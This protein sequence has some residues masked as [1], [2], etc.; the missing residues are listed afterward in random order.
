MNTKRQ[1]HVVTTVDALGFLLPGAIATFIV[2]RVIEYT[3]PPLPFAIPT[4]AMGWGVFVVSALVLGFMI[5]PLA[6]VL[7]R[8]YEKVYRRFRDVKNDTLV[9]FAERE[10]KLFIG[11][12]GSVFDF[13]RK[14]IE[15]A[16]VPKVVKIRRMEGISKLARGVSFFALLAAI[17]AG[18][19]EYW[20]AC[21][22]FLLL[23]VI[24]FFVF[25][26]TRWAAT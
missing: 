9:A 6:Q 21:T 1:D 5:Q 7:D 10:A 24:A 2:L 12:N 11:P 4:G 15:T 22:S 8:V 14:G 18:L 16:G 17:S 20:S 26:E 19:V 25:A 13:A 23:G 3:R